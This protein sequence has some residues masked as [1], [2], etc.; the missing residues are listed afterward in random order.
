MSDAIVSI[1]NSMWISCGSM[2]CLTLSLALLGLNNFERW[3]PNPAE[4]MY[5]R[6]RPSRTGLH[7]APGPASHAPLGHIPTMFGIFKFQVKVEVPGFP[8]AEMEKTDAWAELQKGVA[9]YGQELELTRN[10]VAKER[11]RMSDLLSASYRHSVRQKTGRTWLA[12]VFML[13][14]MVFMLL[15]VPNMRRALAEVRAAKAAQEDF[16]AKGE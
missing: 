15:D 1:R 2:V 7:K 10:E 12:T 4:E 8:V 5:N 6:E 11:D 13:G 16:R 14:A 9:A 3:Y